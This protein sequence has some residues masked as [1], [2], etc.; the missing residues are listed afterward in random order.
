MNNK[1]LIQWIMIAENKEIKNRKKVELLNRYKDINQIC[2]I[3]NI[4]E[5]LSI[6][7]YINYMKKNNIKIL[8]YFDRNYPKA[9]KDLYDAPVIIYAIGNVSIL[10]ERK[11]I[12][13]IGARK[14]SN[15]G[16]YVSQKI[17]QF[18]SRNN[19]NTISGLALGIDVN[20]HIGVLKENR[21]N[22][23]SGRAIAVIGN[24]LDN[25]YPYN[26]QRVAKD[27]INMGGCIISEYIVGTKPKKNN[28]PARNRIISALSNKLIVV[29]AESEKSGTMITVDF[30]LDL[31]KDILVIPGN[32]T[33]KTSLGTNK[34]IS[35]GAK[36]ITELN[37]IIYEEY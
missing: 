26:N 9:L 25:I 20:S 29:E 18:L 16:I 3:L 7:K 15:Y 27:I 36:I 31:G 8:T 13:V 14:A 17:G 5:D 28:F 11:A 24:G 6:N 1:E 33:S 32:I 35:S 10:N 2:K 23:K 4:K 30:S 22:C 12:A 21:I 37:D 19:I 34:L